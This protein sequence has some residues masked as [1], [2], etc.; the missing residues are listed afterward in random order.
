MSS[1]ISVPSWFDNWITNGISSLVLAGI[2]ADIMLQL[3]ELL[4]QSFVFV[5]IRFPTV[6]PVLWHSAEEIQNQLPWSDYHK[7]LL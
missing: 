5:L 6:E 3:S 4:W 2:N 7:L 1:E